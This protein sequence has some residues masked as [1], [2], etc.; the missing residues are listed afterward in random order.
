MHPVVFAEFEAICRA[1]DIRGSVLEIG[2]M[3][4]EST[5]LNLPALLRVREKIGLNKAGAST[6]RGFKILEGEANH[7]S[8]FADQCFDAVLCNAVLEHDPYFW[9][10]LAEI[11]RVVRVGGLVAIG[12]PGYAEL[13]GEK[14]F[15]RWLGRLAPLTRNPDGWALQHAT[16]TLG[17]HNF[18]GD[19]YRFSEQA[20][21]D[22]FFEGMTEVVIRS[23]LVPPR[24]IGSGIRI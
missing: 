1:R 7:M 8:A 15:R 20:F 3:P 2:A 11:R 21:R 10:T 4:E 18:P 24:L 14:K 22:V 17:V 13:R 5:L 23:V 16:L 19:Y 12:T 9:K 6:F